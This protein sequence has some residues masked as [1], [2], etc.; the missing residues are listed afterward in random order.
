MQLVK[1][2]SHH[3]KVTNKNIVSSMQNSDAIYKGFKILAYMKYILF[4]YHYCLGL[5]AC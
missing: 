4:K 1:L 3:D 2:I 5:Y